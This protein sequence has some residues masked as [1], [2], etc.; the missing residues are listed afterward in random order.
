MPVA[1]WINPSNKYVVAPATVNAPVV[2]VAKIAWLPVADVSD[3]AV[4]DTEPHRG[5]NNSN[6]YAFLNLSEIEI[7]VLKQNKV[8]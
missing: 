6:F 2:G 7:A 1:N 8:I 5:E 4:P 3:L